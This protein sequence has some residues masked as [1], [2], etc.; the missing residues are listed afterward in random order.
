[1]CTRA[2]LPLGAPAISSTAHWPST[3]VQPSMPLVSKSNVST[4]RL[5]G[6]LIS[7]GA[8]SASFRGLKPRTP[9]AASAAP[10]HPRR[11]IVPCSMLNL[12]V[13]LLTH[14][15]PLRVLDQRHLSDRM[16]VLH[17]RHDA[18]GAESFVPL[19]GFGCRGIQRALC[20]RHRFALGL[21]VLDV[22]VLRDWV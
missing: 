14:G 4:G 13:E 6:N 21:G 2:L 1:R 17:G 15:L 9:S 16:V 20:L 19:H 22:V 8:A 7:V 11:D 12:L 5:S 3:V 18:D 10:N